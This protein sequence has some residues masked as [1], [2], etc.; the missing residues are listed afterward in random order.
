MGIIDKFKQLA[1]NARKLWGKAIPGAP[2]ANAPLPKTALTHR[3]LWVSKEVHPD[4]YLASQLRL[5][6]IAADIMR[7][8]KG[9]TLNAGVN[10]LKREADAMGQ[11]NKARRRNR[12]ALR[13]QMK[14]DLA[15]TVAMS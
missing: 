3:F 7:R 14:A 1:I 15:Y 8:T 5:P 11:N 12:S 13:K 4:A 6:K 9:H 10:E 2:P